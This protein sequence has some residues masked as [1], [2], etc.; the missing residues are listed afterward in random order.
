V[1]TDKNRSLCTELGAANCYKLEHLK[2]PQIWSLVESSQV[3]FVGGYHL[4]VCPEAALALAEEAAAK[5]KVRP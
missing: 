3:Y 5:N 1:I 2:R 4:T